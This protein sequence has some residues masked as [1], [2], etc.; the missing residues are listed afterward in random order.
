VHEAP[1]GPHR[2]GPETD[3]N[4]VEE[5]Y[6]EVSGYPVVNLHE[7]EAH[8]AWDDRLG[9]V[10]PTAASASRTIFRTTESSPWSTSS[11]P[12]ST[13]RTLA[14]RGPRPSANIC[15]RFEA[16]VERIVR[17]ENRSESCAAVWERRRRGADDRFVDKLPSCC[18]TWVAEA[19]DDEPVVVVLGFPEEAEQAL[20]TPLVFDL[21]RWRAVRRRQ[22]RR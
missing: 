3:T 6:P 10:L 22:R 14:S 8:T 18:E 20:Y 7:R 1:F 15:R 17:H 12:C 19:A 5:R 13:T 9:A 16:G 21:A 4:R 2:G 11:T